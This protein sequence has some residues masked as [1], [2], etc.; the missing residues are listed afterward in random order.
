MALSKKGAAARVS[1]SAAPSLVRPRR[2][3]PSRYATVLA[4]SRNDAGSSSRSLIE[5]LPCVLLCGCC[6]AL[7]LLSVLVGVTTAERA[8]DPSPTQLE[9]HRRTG[10]AI[11]FRLDDHAALVC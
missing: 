2:T 10:V 7:V 5:F 6:S 4:G 9:E 1:K 11:N 8:G 3:R